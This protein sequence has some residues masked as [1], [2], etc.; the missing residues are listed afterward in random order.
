MKK[1]MLVFALA[2][3]MVTCLTARASSVTLKTE[4]EE[5]MGIILDYARGFIYISGEALTPA[6]YDEVIVEL[7]D[8]PIYNLLTGLPVSAGSL[9]PGIEARI[10]YYP[11]ND[12]LDEAAQAVTVWLYPSH[13]DAAVFTTTASDN[14]HY[15]PGYCVFLSA[16]GKYRI[17]L[18]DDN[19]I[20]D[21]TG[22]PLAPEDIEPGQ[23]FFI[24]VDMITASSPA[25][26][27]PDKVV[28]ICQLQ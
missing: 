27:Y 13:Q 2:L 24:W 18:T 22:R 14:I 12:C 1:R 7:G 28:I 9:K 11:Y 3:T 16:D 20:L 5:T 23:A 10:A 25:L 21:S 4:I 8:A 15:G 17:T 26:V 6:G 19:L